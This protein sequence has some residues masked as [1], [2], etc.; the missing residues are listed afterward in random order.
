MT[1]QLSVRETLTLFSL[2][3]ICESGFLAN[4][5]PS[6]VCPGV[7]FQE[8]KSLWDL[9]NKK[10]QE[11]AENAD[12]SYVTRAFGFP[13]SVQSAQFSRQ[14]AFLCLNTESDLS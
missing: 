9:A 12:K 11:S 8:P 5:A 6:G 14:D 10:P 1:L 13:A 7:A 4:P 2:R 3:D